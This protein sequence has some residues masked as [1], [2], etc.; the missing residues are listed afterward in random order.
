M[1]F[2][3]DMKLQIGDELLTVHTAQLVYYS[4]Q[5]DFFLAPFTGWCNIGWIRTTQNGRG[6]SKYLIAAFSILCNAYVQLNLA[7]MYVQ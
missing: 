7:G 4:N 6:P 3:I 5:Q 1:E 2:S